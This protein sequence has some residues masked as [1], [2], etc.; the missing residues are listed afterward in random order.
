[1]LLQTQIARLSDVTDI[2]DF[3][4]DGLVSPDARDEIVQKITSTSVLVTYSDDELTKILEATLSVAK[5]THLKCLNLHDHSFLK[6]SPFLKAER[7]R[8]KIQAVIE[9][10]L[11][12]EK[13]CK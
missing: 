1:M 6:Y 8:L 5:Q 10:L 3:Q 7:P 13:K 4:G 9:I 2:G 12:N 11:N